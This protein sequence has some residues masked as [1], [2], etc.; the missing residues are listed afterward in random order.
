MDKKE[1]TNKLSSLKSATSVSG[2]RYRNIEVRSDKVFFV[3]EG[4]AQTEKI[5]ISELFELYSSEKLI[6]TSNAKLY[7]SGRVQSP[8]VAILNALETNISK[9]ETYQSI[10]HIPKKQGFKM[11]ESK[12]ET[13]FFSVLS[14]LLGKNYLLS[15]SIGKPVNSGHIFLSKSYKSF[16]MFDENGKMLN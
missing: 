5:S 9:V 6:N 4:K 11:E 2:K 16:K 7:I 12:D 3:R 10:P 13:R 14:D 8:A 1:F 15:K